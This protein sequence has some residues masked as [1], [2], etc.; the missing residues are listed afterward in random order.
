MSVTVDH[1][2]FAAG[3]I[4]G[5]TAIP[6]AALFYTLYLVGRIVTKDSDRTAMGLWFGRFCLVMGVVMNCVAALYLGRWADFDPDRAPQWWVT[7]FSVIGAI[8]LLTG[9]PIAIQLGPMVW[10]EIARV[11]GWER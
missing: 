11:K 9:I 10:R 2:Q 1:I 7:S 8:A 6:Y 4:L 3:L 5:I